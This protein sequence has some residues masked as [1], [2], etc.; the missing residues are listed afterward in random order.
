METAVL[1]SVTGEPAARDIIQFGLS[2]S[3]KM[4]VVFEF[5]RV[6]MPGCMDSKNDRGLDK[7][8]RYMLRGHACAACS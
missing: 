7:A 5:R 4:Y 6:P 1:Q 2:D 8:A 3:S